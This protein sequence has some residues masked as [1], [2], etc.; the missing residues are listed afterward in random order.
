M[1]LQGSIGHLKRSL[2][3]FYYITRTVVS[4]VAK[5]D[6]VFSTDPQ[7]WWIKDLVKEAGIH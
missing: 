6:Q 7:L 5:Y 3:Q 1:D 4:T 2:G